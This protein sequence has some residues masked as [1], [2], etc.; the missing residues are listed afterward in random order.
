M[1][2]NFLGEEVVEGRVVIANM[3]RCI[4]NGDIS[5]ALRLLQTFLETVPYWDNTAYEGHYQQMMYVIFS[6]LTPYRI[7]VEQHTSRGRTDITLETELYVYVME[8]KFGK[9]ADEALVQIEDRKYAEAFAL[10][11]KDVVKVGINFDVDKEHNIVEWK[12]SGTQ[13]KN[14]NNE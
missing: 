9:S 5:G 3:S 1:L 12:V 14:N 10:S 7:T 11:G 13:T 2:P 8:L 6:L 4:N